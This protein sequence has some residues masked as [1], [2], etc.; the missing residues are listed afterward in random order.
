MS[1]EEVE[2][3]DK[4][5]ILLMPSFFDSTECDI[6]GGRYPDFKRCVNDGKSGVR[7]SDRFITGTLPPPIG[8]IYRHPKLVD[9]AR[10]LYGDNVALYMN[11][12]L[13]KDETWAGSVGPHQDA[14][15]LNGGQEKTSVFVPLTP[16]SPRTGGL[17]FLE[18]SH[19]YGNI[20]VGDIVLDKFPSMP[21][22]GPEL[23]VG[24]ILV[25]HLFTWHY[26]RVP[27][28]RRERALLQIVYQPS[29]DGS[30]EGGTMRGPTLVSGEWQTDIF[31]PNRYGVVQ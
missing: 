27:V 7:R 13:L 3:F 4:R 11:R 12:V 29:S 5:G 1:P 21:E 26:S 20:G 24:D 19:E 15:Y 10:Q 6:W 30:F 23:G 31:V 9:L 18:G 17:L 16:Q 22:F 25:S 2:A 28:E 8:T 14:P